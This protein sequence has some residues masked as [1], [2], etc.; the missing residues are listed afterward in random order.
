VIGG[1]VRDLISHNAI[2]FAAGGY[3][4]EPSCCSSF[5][6]SRELKL[7]GNRRIQPAV[8]RRW[9]P[10]AQTTRRA[11]SNV[12]SMKTISSTHGQSGT[13]TVASD[14]IRPR[15]GPH[16]ARRALMTA[17][18]SAA[19]GLA[20][21]LLG[22]GH[23]AR[24]LGSPLNF[25]RVTTDVIDALRAVSIVVDPD[26]ALNSVQTDPAL[27]PGSAGGVPVNTNGKTIGA[28][29]A[30]VRLSAAAHISDGAW[31]QRGA[32]VRTEPIICLRGVCNPKE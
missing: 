20:V 1:L 5:A 7:V 16:A 4:G 3:G 21:A 10:A 27:N 23:P 22:F 6:R 12:R 11:E 28:N 31:R 32:A 13:E 14:T 2:R 18:F 26:H 24:P 15:V 19:I 8:T 9:Q 25:D 17:T 30:M 29:P